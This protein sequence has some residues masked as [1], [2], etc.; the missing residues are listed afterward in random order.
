[1]NNRLQRHGLISAGS[2]LVFLL[3]FAVFLELPRAGAQLLSPQLLEL[4]CEHLWEIQQRYLSRHVLYQNNRAPNLE[5][6]T[7]DQFV[8]RLDGSKMYFLQSDVNSIDRSMAKLFGKLRSS[9][10][11]AIEKANRLLIKKMKERVAFIK[12]ELGPKFKFNPNVKLVLD[13]DKRER[14]KTI[15]ELNS[16]QRKY[17]QF[18]VANYLA[19]DM[20]LEEAKQRV[21]RNYERVLR[22]V[23]ETPDRE[24]WANYMDSFARAL[25]PHS[26]FLSK[27]AL[28]DFEIQMR[29]SL[30]GIGATLSSQDGFTVI[31]QLIAGGAAYESGKLKPKDKIIEVAQGDN[32]EPQNVIEM[33]LRDVVRLIRGKKGSKVKLT[34]LR[35]EAEGSKRFNV[36]LVRDK[37]KL[38]DEAAQVS[39]YDR[40]VNGVKKK[41]ALL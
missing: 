18:Q 15:A 9:N 1:M 27:D 4:K 16:F 40:E 8:K 12:K 19:S 32:G 33:D 36:V 2:L 6:R 13:P 28:E 31:E 10:C 5:R 3:A 7:A 25:D 30:E 34:I 11:S 26:S 35:K 24:L 20:T 22:R 14:A 17:L 21:I 38:E 39:Y 37:I 41:V 23:E 29:L